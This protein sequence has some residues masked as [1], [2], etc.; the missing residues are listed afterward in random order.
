ME[1]QKIQISKIINAPIIVAI[2]GVILTVFLSSQKAE[3]RYTLSEEIPINL[4]N[5]R[6]QN[7]QQL[8]IKNTGDVLAEKIVI[9]I[10]GKI[11]KYSIICYSK[12]DVVEEF[13]EE[14]SLQLVYPELPKQ[15]SIQITFI[16]EQQIEDSDIE[17]KYNKGLAE[18]AL[19][20]DMD[21]GI[22]L[23]LCYVII[24]GLIVSGIYKSATDFDVKYYYQKYLKRRKKFWYINNE[25]WENL[26]KESI[27]AWQKELM[28]ETIK[29]YNISNISKTK[30]F[31]LLN[32]KPEY[33]LNDEWEILR[34]T[35]TEAWQ[36]LRG[37]FLYS[38]HFNRDE[39]FK[40]FLKIE[41]P[42]YLAESEWINTRNK[43]IE[44]TKF[45]YI[46]YYYK[47]GIEKAYIFLN[48]KRK[49][50]FKE[51]EWQQLV[52]LAFS[53]LK[54]TFYELLNEVKEYE[55]EKLEKYFLMTRPLSAD[56]EEWRGMQTDIYKQFINLNIKI[57]KNKVEQNYFSE[58]LEL[59]GISC[60]SNLT[61]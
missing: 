12:M 59:M 55:A 2:I 31:I 19:S 53:Y 24:I 58:A 8:V 26:R 28:N 50:Y 56:E 14:N 7:V 36:I 10:N 35:A 37:E 33:L 29:W 4:T 16:G 25:R 23:I 15:G 9:N 5:E 20:S 21:A 44:I 54:N 18:E 22:F 43:I 45:N 30:S 27:I 49:P 38:P 46:K 48:Q 13:L 52:N 3:L 57:V 40:E 17:I 11:E 1:K 61:I 6:I 41:K 32:E 39:E 42:T 47:E 51:S 60:P 34:N